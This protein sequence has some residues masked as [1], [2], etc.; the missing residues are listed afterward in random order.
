MYFL[1]AAY[2]SCVPLI[3]QLLLNSE[4]LMLAELLAMVLLP[5]SIMRNTM[6][7]ATP[8][9]AKGIGQSSCVCNTMPVHLLHQISPSGSAA[10]WPLLNSKITSF[11]GMVSR[12]ECYHYAWYLTGLADM[13]LDD[14]V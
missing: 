13:N 4:C 10:N 14:I 2:I 1:T 12:R 11:D 8:I 7:L 3:L 6:N 5:C 9:R